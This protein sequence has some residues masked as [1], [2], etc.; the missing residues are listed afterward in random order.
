VDADEVTY[1]LHVILRF[2]LEKALLAGELEVADIPGAWNEG[3]EA[4]VGLSPG[5][6][7]A[8]GC[9][10][11]VHWFAGLFGYFPTY[12]L[13]ALIAAQLFS[14]ARTKEPG[15]E[16]AIADGDFG[17]IL[18]WLRKNVHG[19]GQLLDADS[20]VRTATGAPL[21]T[22]AFKEHL[23]VRYLGD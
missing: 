9:M 2:R 7:L 16:A 22:E 5:D 20:L 19:R 10:Q 14:A 21:A 17:P 13:G 1:P 15:I 18:S 6:N 8:D 23:R 12:T 11:D 3:M 4:L